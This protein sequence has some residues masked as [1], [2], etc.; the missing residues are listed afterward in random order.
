[1]NLLKSLC[2][3]SPIVLFCVVALQQHI[4][5]NLSTLT[6]WKGGGMGMYSEPALRTRSLLLTM[7][8]PGQSDIEFVVRPSEWPA[9]NGNARSFPTQAHL[10]QLIRE[11]TSMK[12]VYQDERRDGVNTVE[13]GTDYPEELV[14][15]PSSVRIDSRELVLDMETLS[16]RLRTLASRVE[17]R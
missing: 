7:E 1:M 6:R 14:I 3:Y 17:R 15:H 11:I 16:A 10:E 9:Q 13:W 8:V 12:W 2:L 5:S 4:L